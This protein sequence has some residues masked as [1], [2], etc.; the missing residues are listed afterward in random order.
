VVL[1]LRPSPKLDRQH[2]SSP[3]LERRY[4]SSRH[5]ADAMN[6]G[7]QKPP[8]PSDDPE[9][10]RNTSSDARLA[11]ANLNLQQEAGVCFTDALEQCYV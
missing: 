10:L 3:R 5:P 1:E 8:Q 9:S 11:E 4:M 7:R 6:A 2:A